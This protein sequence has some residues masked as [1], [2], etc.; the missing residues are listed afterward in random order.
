MKKQTLKF[1][2]AAGLAL[3]LAASA[4][5]GS[6]NGAASEIPAYYDGNLFAIQFVEFPPAAEKSLLQHNSQINFID[7]SDPGLPGGEPFISVIDAIP[8]DG[9]NP[10]WEEV[11]ISFTSGNTPHQFFSDN[12]VLAAAAG[13]EITLTPTG[14]VYW[15][16]LVG[17]KP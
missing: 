16:P 6:G 14:E 7:Q 13:G 1:F 10:V 9:F 15:C 3:A 4:R 11:Q 5:A 12:E 17:Q 8:G 2:G